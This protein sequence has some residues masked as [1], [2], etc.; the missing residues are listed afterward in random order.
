MSSNSSKWL[1]GCAIGCGALVVL[2]IILGTSGYV[3]IKSKLQRFEEAKTAVSELEAKYGKAQDFTAES[4]GSIKPERIKAFLAVRDNTAPIRQK[5]M[6]SLEHISQETRRARGGEKSFWEGMK[7]ISEG[8]GV[9]PALGEFYAA[10]ARALLDAQ[11][12]MGEYCYLYVIAYYSWLGK[13]PEDGPDFRLAGGEQASI[14]ASGREDVREE[15]RYRMVQWIRRMFLP[16]L[17]NQLAR[18]KSSELTEARQSW[19]KILESEI[20]ALEANRDRLPWQDGLPEVL[21]SS[22][23]PFRAQ[24]DSSYSVILNPLELEW[25]SQTQGPRDHRY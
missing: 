10:R 14:E 19:R 15:R 23:R 7:I 11:M 8:I 4:D 12:G 20:A 25:W 6:E 16:M 9:I 5:L 1:T 22:L 18:L 2:A 24:V 13:A 3:F 17:R 21:E